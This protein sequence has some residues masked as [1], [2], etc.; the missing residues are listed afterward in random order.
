[1]RSTSRSGRRALESRA[2]RPCHALRGGAAHEAA[3][4][5]PRGARDPAARVVDR[6][7]SPRSPRG[8]RT[9]IAASG[10]RVVGDLATLAPPVAEPD[11]D[12]AEGP[13]RPGGRAAGDRRA[14]WRWASCRGRPG[15]RTADE[16][17]RAGARVRR[18][19]HPELAGR[20]HDRE[21]DA[22]VHDARG[23]GA[24]DARRTRCATGRG[25][26]S[27]ARPHSGPAPGVG[28]VGGRSPTI[29][30]PRRMEPTADRDPLLLP[31]GTQ[32]RPHRPA[33]DRHDR[34]PG[35]VPAARAAAEAAGRPLRG[36]PAPLGRARSRRSSASPGST[37]STR[38]RS[39]SALAEA[40]RRGPRALE[41]RAGRAEQRVLR[42][43]AA[44]GDPPDRRRP[45]R[46]AGST[47]SSRCGRSRGSS[48]R[49][50]SS[51]S[52]ATSRSRSTTG[53]TRCFNQEPDKITPSF[54]NRHRHD[55]LIARWAEVVGYD[56]M[57]VV[58]ARRGRPRLRPAGLRAAD[59]PARRA[60][61]VAPPE[62]ANRSLTMPE[63]EAV[64]A[65]N[66]A[67]R[68]EGLGRPLHSRVMNFGAARYMKAG[69]SRRADAPRVET[70]QWALD[71]AG[72][73]G[74]RDGRRDRGD[75]GS[76][77]IGDLEP[78]TDGPDRAASTATTSR[79]SPSRRRSP[80]SMAMGVLSRAASR[81]E[82]G[83]EGDAAGRAGAGRRRVPIR[84]EPIELV[85]VPDARPVR[86]ARAP[87]GGV[88]AAPAARAASKG[89]A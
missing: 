62:A 35:R 61:S 48:R 42:R 3:R 25:A 33:Q 81:R 15:A 47:S 77:S 9:R 41:G 59:G 83:S 29:D 26:A 66:V 52:R 10:V 71:R 85:R 53:S 79:R 67:F 23:P 5:G 54:W 70:P 12:A 78:L 36:P 21:P 46:R 86:R 2:P 39:I 80:P 87:R 8:S 58:V 73:G 30:G 68:Q 65:F 17:C 72:V 74:A 18:G 34:A 38:R 43:C 50:G 31:E 1:M 6:P 40:G 60:R 14:R 22:G 88:G 49:S 89:A 20:G 56:R 24:A 55:R 28:I 57:T 37:R 84:G 51:T 45:R 76:G 69:A 44:R 16:R 64:R 19:R 4:A 63:V 11:A 27:P 82:H 7:G 75:A 32:P 13:R